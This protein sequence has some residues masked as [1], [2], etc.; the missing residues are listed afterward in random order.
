[1]GQGCLYRGWGYVN[2]GM[3]REGGSVIP[4]GGGGMWMELSK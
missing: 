1:M 2:N 3:R 4:K